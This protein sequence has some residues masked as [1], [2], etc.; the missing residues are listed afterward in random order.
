MLFP[1]LSSST[2]SIFSYVAGDAAGSALLHLERNGF[3]VQL[4]LWFV[5]RG[6]T[7]INPL[8]SPALPED[9]YKISIQQCE[10]ISSQNLGRK[11]KSLC[12]LAKWK[13]TGI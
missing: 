8:P 9:R 13:T 2:S 5:W 3:W 10:N 12:Y 11:K 7:E 1:T 6:G 4:V